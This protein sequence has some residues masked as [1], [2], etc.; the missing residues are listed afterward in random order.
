MESEKQKE[1][2]K[3]NKNLHPQLT[4]QKRSSA[5]FPFHL[6]FHDVF[7]GYWTDQKMNRNL[8]K[9]VC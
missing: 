7:L 3:T 2:T 9:N 4:L 5:V 1:I 8:V 6:F